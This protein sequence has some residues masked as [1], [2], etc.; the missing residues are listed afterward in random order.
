M[1]QPTDQHLVAAERILRYVQGSLHHG[2]TFHP[3]PLT[4]TAYTDSDWVSD[5][6]DHRSTIGL[7]I[8]LSHN[9]IT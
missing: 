4:L 2:L 8:F 7:I 3:G 6:M 1:H 9:P 5:P